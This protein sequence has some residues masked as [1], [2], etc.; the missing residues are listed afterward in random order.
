M[1]RYTIIGPAR[2][3]T[4][5]THL[6]LAGH[7]QIS[8]LNDEVKVWP[9]FKL[10]ISVFT[11][12]HNRKEEVAQGFRK[13]FDA[14][15]F[16]NAN[17]MTRAGGI[18]CAVTSTEEVDVF[19]DCVRQFF[20]DMMIILTIRSDLLAQLGSLKRSRITGQAHSW[21]KPRSAAPVRFRIDQAEYNHYLF[22]NLEMIER[23]RALKLT[24]DCLEINYEQDILHGL[25]NL[26]EKLFR[27]LQVDPVEPTWLNSHKVSPPPQDYILNYERLKTAEREWLEHKRVF[28]YGIVR[29]MLRKIKCLTGYYA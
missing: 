9:L 16:L 19:V 20:P 4:T 26:N 28:K 22:A 8:A 15:A 29:R 6:I 1:N 13:L 24:H 17:E 27:F 10:G 3:G 14:L 5:I 7:P 23:L 18:K 12:G 25:S 21:I 11:F 2:S